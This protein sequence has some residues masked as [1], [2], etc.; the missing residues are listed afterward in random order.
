MIAEGGLASHNAP[1]T[2]DLEVLA[3]VLQEGPPRA[4]ERPLAGLLDSLAH[5][6]G[7]AAAWFAKDLAEVLVKLCH[8]AL[9]AQ[10]LRLDEAEQQEAELSIVRSISARLVERA[11]GL[12]TWVHEIESLVDQPGLHGETGS[13]AE[14]LARALNEGKRRRFRP[15]LALSE[16]RDWRNRFF[17]HGALGDEER[18]SREAIEQLPR[19]RRLL[20]AIRPL[21]PELHLADLKSDADKT[22][23]GD[24]GLRPCLET[25]TVRYAGRE[26]RPA[27]QALEWIDVARERVYFRGA[28]DGETGHRRRKDLAWP[29]LDRVEALAATEQ[30]EPSVR[31]GIGGRE[32]WHGSFAAGWLRHL[33][34][35]RFAGFSAGRYLEPEYLVEQVESHFEAAPGGW[36]RVV[37]VAGVGKSFLCQGLCRRWRDGASDPALVLDV[38][39]QPGDGRRVGVFVNSLQDVLSEETSRLLK[40]SISLQR[41]EQTLQPQTNAFDEWLGVLANANPWAERIVFLIDGIDE[42]EPAEAGATLTSLFPSEL[43][44]G[45]YGVVSGRPANVLDAT[46]DHELRQLEWIGEVEI[47]PASEQNQALLRRWLRDSACE[48]ADLEA[49][50]ARAEG[51]F[52]YADHFSRWAR[53][54]G[55]VPTAGS[56]YEEIL[57]WLRK[58][59]EPIP[60]YRYALDRILGVLAWAREPVPLEVFLTAGVP[61]DHIRE[62]L[63]DLHDLLARELASPNGLQGEAEPY[64]YRIFHRELMDHLRGHAG[65]GER[66]RAFL[67]EWSSVLLERLE[68]AWGAADPADVRDTYT[69]THLGDHLREAKLTPATPAGLV[70]CLYSL[71]VEADSLREEQEFDLSRRWC[72][73]AVRLAQ[74]AA[75]AP[76]YPE[77]EWDGWSWS[78]LLVDLGVSARQLGD[79]DTAEIAFGLARSTRERALEQC[80]TVKTL[81][82][83]GHTW[84]LTGRIAEAQGDFS[85][86]DFAY[87]QDLMLSQ[88]AVRFEETSETLRNLGVAWNSVGSLAESKGNLEA[89]ESAFR[90]A[91][92]IAR[93]VLKHEESSSDL[94]SLSAALTSVGGVA[95]ARGDLDAAEVA[96]REALTISMHASASDDNRDSVRSLS[97]A[98]NRLGRVLQFKGDFSAAEEAFRESLKLAERVLEFGA[99]PGALAGLSATWGAIGGVAQ[100]RGD[101]GT[102]E[103]AYR[104]NLDYAQRVLECH[105]TLDAMGSLAL[106]WRCV[107]E[108]ASAKQ[109]VDSARAA[110]CESLSL[111]QRVLERSE[112]PDALGDVASVWGRLSALAEWRGD[113]DE[114]EADCRRELEH[115]QRA[116]EICETPATLSMLSYSWGAIGRIAESRGELEAAEVAYRKDLAFSER[117]LECG[118]RPGAL[119]DLATSWSSLGRLAEC[120]SDLEAAEA[121]YGEALALSQRAVEICESPESLSV[122]ARAWH[123]LGSLACSRGDAAA[124]EAAYEQD[125]HFSQRALAE[126]ETPDALRELALT[127][128][129]LGKITSSHGDLDRAE[130]AYQRTLELSQRVLSYGETATALRELAWTWRALGGIAEARGD[131][132]LAGVSHSN[133]VAHFE[134]SLSSDPRPGRLRDLGDGWQRIGELARAQGDL[135]RAEAAFRQ[136]L[137]LSEAI[138]QLDETLAALRELS[139]GWHVLGEI[140]LDQGDMEAARIAFGNELPLARRVLEQDESEEALLARFHHH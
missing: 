106:A 55:Q 89:A 45:V 112:T 19:L 132:E 130:A 33:N 92:R 96:F 15:R 84:N 95:K 65:E 113:L 44:E 123:R 8:A 122:L 14:R 91:L 121:A 116:L 72:H 29:E 12:G 37:G 56:F 62:A 49:L 118:E 138:L 3:A 31:L 63:L 78:S 28:E 32:G 40:H 115:L 137:R 109:D 101:L 6:R 128:A 21:F 69:I 18:A 100:S 93:Q 17:G 131:L 59:A 24:I 4:V 107:G 117:V 16:L 57:A 125:L 120:R 110:F 38:F 98:W 51:R 139:A 70:H 75:E 77:P 23:W 13:L 61:A 136:N 74:G 26:R 124:A 47:N 34:A 25:L 134:R 79:L 53:R 135:A 119:S 90:V 35:L 7:A 43:P 140:A 46:V 133:F 81:S 76:D 105:E 83:L 80:E 94:R 20:D 111:A 10:A 85:N 88:R 67:Q 11:P 48:A 54:L 41:P 103:H 87:Q 58:R 82:D 64:V 36:L 27:L 5:D 9:V 2:N 102:A 52:L 86:A 114:A 127:W 108:I 73:G 97:V 104:E 42:L 50:I 39:L 1:V 99:T 60:R 22:R 71:S 129:T 126:H 68:G 66:Q 30:E